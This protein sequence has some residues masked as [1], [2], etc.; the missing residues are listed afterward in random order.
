VLWSPGPR[1][2]ALR[3][4]LGAERRT[5][6]SDDATDTPRLNRVAVEGDLAVV[7]ATRPGV[8]LHGFI[9]R[10]DRPGVSVSAFA[11]P[12]AD[13]RDFLRSSPDLFRRQVEALEPSLLVFMLGG[14]E[15]R[16]VGRR[17]SGDRAA[18]HLDALVARA[19]DAAPGAG[20]LI[21][22][23]M[24]RV[25]RS[26]HR[27][28]RP[29]PGLDVVIETQRRV[30]QHRGCALMDLH[31]GAGGPGTIQRWRR[32]GLMHA[33]LTHPTTLGRE[34]IGQ[35]VVDGILAGYVA[36]EESRSSRLTVH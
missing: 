25:R 16:R 26:S 12:G 8:T 20:C 11:T 32:R 10:A 14:N 22:T 35:L 31:A 36:R 18:L 1:S 29:L 33:D 23:P 7:R 9:L 24:E 15:A 17:Y 2:G 27:A 6:T 3:I 4:D 13:A 28:P 34:L 30:A 5:L 19:Q 21:I